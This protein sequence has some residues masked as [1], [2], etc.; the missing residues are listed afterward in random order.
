MASRCFG[1]TTQHSD[2]LK[3]I[4]NCLPNTVLSSDVYNY[5]LVYKKGFVACP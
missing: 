5:F 4:I 2:Y 3:E 1:L